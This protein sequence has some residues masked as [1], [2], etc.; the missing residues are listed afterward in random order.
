MLAAVSGTAGQVVTYEDA[1]AKVY[2]SSISGG[3]TV[4]SYD[5]WGG[6]YVPYLIGMATEWEKY[7]DYSDGA[8]TTVLTG[9]RLCEMLQN[10]GYN[11]SGR[12]TDVEILEF[13][14]NSEYVKSIRFTDE[15]GKQISI[16]YS[17]N[18]RSA[19]SAELR[20]ACFTVEKQ[21]M[22]EPEYIEHIVPAQ[23][24]TGRGTA[25]MP[26]NKNLI[27]AT[28]VGILSLRADD[29]HTVLTAGGR[30]SFSL[31]GEY[32]FNDRADEEN[33]RMRL[34]YDASEAV[35]VF[36]GKGFGHGVGMSQLGAKNLADAGKSCAEIIA[37]YFPGTEIKD[38]DG[39]AER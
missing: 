24:L 31:Y 18:I 3:S 8:W 7:E 25:T 32:S 28:G 12:I 34:E 26:G 20:S 19:L 14:E 23:V 38:K 9:T 5:A 21:G 37:A 29:S 15:N 17:D 6:L 11:V 27:V 35:F 36:R 1:L 30:E 16:Y 22:Q 10:K 4:S 2:Y 13:A 39:I 33:E